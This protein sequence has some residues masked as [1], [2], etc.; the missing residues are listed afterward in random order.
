[1]PSAA[2]SLRDAFVQP[3][4]PFKRHAYLLRGVHSDPPRHPG[5]ADVHQLGGRARPRVLRHR[6]RS[7][8]PLGVCVMTSTAPVASPSPTRLRVVPP[9]VIS[10]ATPSVTAPTCTRRSDTA[11]IGSSFVSTSPSPRSTAAPTNWTSAAEA[12]WHPAPAG[13][14]QLG[15][16]VDIG[17]RVCGSRPAPDSPACCPAGSRRARQPGASRHRAGCPAA[18]LVEH[19]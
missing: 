10:W 1:V 2:W 13:G 6:V 18:V 12:G 16:R 8:S 14:L 11:S 9:V 3:S 17:R 7:A 4:T 15:V 5:A 19:V